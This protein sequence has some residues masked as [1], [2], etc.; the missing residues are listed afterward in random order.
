MAIA[1]YTCA[2][3]LRPESYVLYMD[4]GRARQSNKQLDAAAADFDRSVELQPAQP[5]TYLNRG[6][7]RLL[8]G[9]EGAAAT[10]FERC[11]SLAPG[12]KAFCE[13]RISDIKEQLSRK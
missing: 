1:D 11:L 9:R 3:D 10:D 12:L 8:Q 2:I 5:L 7:L 13:R 6:L 4:R